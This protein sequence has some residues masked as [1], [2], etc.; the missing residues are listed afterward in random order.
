MAKGLPPHLLPPEAEDADHTAWRV[1]LIIGLQT[2][3]GP[4]PCRFHRNQ[5]HGFNL[6]PRLSAMNLASSGDS[7]HFGSSQ[8]E[9]NPKSNPI[10]VHLDFKSHSPIKR[11][12]FWSQK[13]P[14]QGEVSGKPNFETLISVALWPTVVL[15]GSGGVWVEHKHQ[16]GSDLLTD[17]FLREVGTCSH[18]CVLYAYVDPG[19]T[20]SWVHP[21]L[22]LQPLPHLLLSTCLLSVSCMHFDT[23]DWIGQFS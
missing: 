10:G 23:M 4:S 19:T 8:R 16:S 2:S 18:L 13:P 22:P 1:Q 7:F 15:S 6:F 14:A 17:I 20:L 9:R 3:I 5:L 11:A 12:G 21:C